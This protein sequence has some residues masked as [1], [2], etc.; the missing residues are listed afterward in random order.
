MSSPNFSHLKFRPVLTFEQ[1]TNIC[2]LCKSN[3]TPE[4]ASILKTLIPLVAKIEIGAINPAYKLS[5]THAIKQAESSERSKYE[6]G[7]MNPEEELAYET[8]ILGV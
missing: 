7:L 5:E 6:N 8:K 2:A 1:I 3:P 4:T